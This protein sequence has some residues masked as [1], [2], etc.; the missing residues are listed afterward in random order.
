MRRTAKVIN[1][2][3]VY[4]ISGFGLSKE[5]G[6]GPR[7]A[8][9]YIDAYFERHKGIKEYIERT[10]TEAREKGFVRTLFGRIRYIPEL[11]NSDMNVRQFGERTAMNTP[12]QGTAADIIKDGDGEH[13]PQDEGRTVPVETHHA[14][15][16]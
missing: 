4:G 8:Q 9:A 12:I 11:I 13:L 7:E 16:R 6:V 3:I 15:T 14:D 10:V 5:L 1:F 2:G